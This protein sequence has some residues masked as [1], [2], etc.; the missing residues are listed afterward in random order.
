MKA[1][2]IS[3]KEP[4]RYDTVQAEVAIL[5]PEFYWIRKIDGNPKEKDLRR[6]AKN[7]FE[8]KEKDLIFFGWKCKNGSFAL[9]VRQQALFMLEKLGIEIFFPAQVFDTL[10]PNGSCIQVGKKYALVKYGN[11]WIIVEKR[12]VQNGSEC[13]KINEALEIL[14][15]SCE[16]IAITKKHMR[17]NGTKY[18]LY[19]MA[20]AAAAVSLLFFMQG[21]SFRL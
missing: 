5:S 8:D 15:P 1:V 19:Y 14:S 6:I 21:L 16:P 13:K 4:V 10:F 20:T 18:K 11:L 2:F 7:I 12:S 17:K 9:A 3:E